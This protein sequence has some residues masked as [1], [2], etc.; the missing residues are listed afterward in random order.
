L[1]RA[2]EEGFKKATDYIHLNY[3]KRNTVDESISALFRHC[4]LIIVYFPE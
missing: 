4:K 1:Q 2:T 3:I